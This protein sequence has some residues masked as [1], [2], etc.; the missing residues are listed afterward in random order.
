M[1]QIGRKS[2]RK[3]FILTA[4]QFS[5]YVRSIQFK[6]FIFLFSGST[7]NHRIHQQKWFSLSNFNIS[8][9]TFELLNLSQYVT[10]VHMT[11]NIINN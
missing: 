1:F 5:N 2:Y 9:D 7:R 11:K 8:A 4:E 10:S 6:N 3:Y